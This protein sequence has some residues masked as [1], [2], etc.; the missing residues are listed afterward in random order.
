MPIYFPPIVASLTLLAELGQP[1]PLSIS[2]EAIQRAVA[3]EL[4][5]ERER[6]KDEPSSSAVFSAQSMSDNERQLRAFEALV[7]EAE[8]PYCL[9][10]D[11]L[12]RQPTSI[13]PIGVSGLLALPFV[14]IA[15][16][17]GKCKM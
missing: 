15:A 4:A 17:R 16:L 8:V 6:T 5:D 9:H 3:A 7:K 10:Q 14:P 13:G 2:R 12:K 11:G 1:Q